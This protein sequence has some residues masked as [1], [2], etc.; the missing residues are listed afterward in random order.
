MELIN[1]HSN[2]AERER[3]LRKKKEEIDLQLNAIQDDVLKYR[4]TECIIKIDK[5]GVKKKVEMIDFIDCC[6]FEAET[7]RDHRIIDNDRVEGTIV[8]KNAKK[9]LVIEFNIGCFH[10]SINYYTKNRKINSSTTE[11]R[12]YT[13]LEH[14]MDKYIGFTNAS[15]RDLLNVFSEYQL[16]YVDCDIETTIDIMNDILSSDDSL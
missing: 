15:F 2:I 9:Q 8:W 11:K 12:N 5:F 14:K 7:L 1:K 10:R 13:K 16:Y 6:S 4:F 3:E